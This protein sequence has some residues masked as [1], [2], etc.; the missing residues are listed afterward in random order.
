MRLPHPRGPVSTAVV[1][2]LRR[3]PDDFTAGPAPADSDR[4]VLH[5]DDLQLTLWICYELGYRGFDDVDPSWEHSPF[6]TGLRGQLERRWEAGLRDLVPPIDVEPEDVPK[7]LVELVRAD[8][9]P[10]LAKFL[11]R[12]AS[13]AQFREFVVHRSVYHLKEADPHSWAI[14]RLSGAAKV[15][16]L[17][18]Q[19]DEYGEGRLDRMHSE[20]FRATMRGLSLDDGYGHYVDD[21]PAV[22]LAVSNLMSFFGFHRRWLG[23]TLGHLA[24][25]EM[26]SSLPNRRYGNGLRRLGGDEPATRFYDVHVEADAVHEQIA[27]HDL[28][29][30]FAR[31]NP[32]AATDV[33]FGA[34]CGLA[35]E[36]EFGRTLLTHWGNDRSALVTTGGAEPADLVGAVAERFDGGQSAS[37]ERDRTPAGI[38]DLAVR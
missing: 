10:S 5:D 17:E 24:A 21:V 19:S 9:G 2:R 29:G 28:C 25:F 32:S 15:A 26:T 1:D 6:V 30:T 16:L 34:A 36:A 22:T 35:V 8:D 20:L 27:A 7:A 14:P 12:R 23:A 3:V 4:P 18:I 33:L 31:E 38:D 11:Q 37:A 13:T